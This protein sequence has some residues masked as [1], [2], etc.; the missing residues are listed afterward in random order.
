MLDLE[1]IKQRIG[2]PIAHT[3]LVHASPRT[4]PDWR[5]SYEEADRDRAALVAEVERLRGYLEA[6]GIDTDPCA[7]D[8][9]DGPGEVCLSCAVRAALG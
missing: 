5:R 2:K 1:P 8:Q 9:Y 4:M 7:C 3:V 6:T